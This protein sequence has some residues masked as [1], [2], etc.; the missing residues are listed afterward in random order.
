MI[1]FSIKTAKKWR[2]LTPAPPCRVPSGERRWFFTC[3]KTHLFC[4]CPFPMLCLS[5]ACRGKMIGSYIKWHRKTWIFFFTFFTMRSKSRLITRSLSGL[6]GTKRR[7]HVP[8][9]SVCKKRKEGKRQKR[10]PKKRK[11]KERR[12]KEKASPHL[13]KVRTKRMPYFSARSASSFA[14]SARLFARPLFARSALAFCALFRA[15]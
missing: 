13:S 5:R 4:E 2:F 9:V 6:C 7:F 14:S 11:G 3:E 10:K 8:I 15:I 12:K 1:F